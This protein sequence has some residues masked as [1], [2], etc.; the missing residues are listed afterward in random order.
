MIKTSKIVSGIKWTAIQFVFD[1]IFRFSIRLILATILLPKDFGLVGMCM[2][3][4][5][6]S[7]AASELGMSAAL[8]QKKNDEEAEEM[9]STAFWSG[10]LWGLGIFLL[11]S[12]VIGPFAASF[13]E[14]P[15]LNIL[16]PVL[17]LGILI[18]PFSLIHTVILTRNMDFKSL[19]TIL[20]ISALIAGVF[21]ITGAYM[22]DLGVW[23]LIANSLLTVILSLPLLFI[24][25]KWKPKL[26]WNKLH[27][28]NIFGFGAYSSGTVMFS[29]LTYN[30]DN[31][32]IGKLLGSSLLGAYAL[33]FSLTEQFRQAISGIL[34][35]VMYPVYG[36]SQDNKDKL[37]GYF[38]Q[39]ININAILI[40]PIMTFLLFFAEEI[41]IGFFGEKWIESIIPLKI[42]AIGMMVHLLV[43]S[44]TSLIRGLGK[45]KLEM[46]IIMSLT[47][48]VLIPGLYLGI[49]N[50]GLT[51]AAFAI[52]LNKVCLAVV[53]LFV[54]NREI[55]V[56][57]LNVYQSVKGAIYSILISS[58]VVFLVEKYVY[59]NS[60]YL[61]GAFILTYLLLIYKFEKKNINA[62]ISNLIEKN[63]N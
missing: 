40:Y 21:S 5:A 35:K 59:D 55:G 32:M 57:L 10:L 2:V 3:F 63:I 11:L 53:G 22:F 25:T 18:K 42:L 56:S 43:N 61:F 31:L 50:Y 37:K 41:I 30:I 19:A 62:V 15:M 1:F 34:N 4:I 52:L 14:E 44:F 38:L 29:T 58:L 46:K 33:S 47:I 12:F 20:N 16:I 13:Y 6:V 17:S 27:F 54:L 39:I 36:K 60:I 23:A 9:Y 49:T 8:I 24:K 51:G 48:F 28:K 7:G 45:P 26:E